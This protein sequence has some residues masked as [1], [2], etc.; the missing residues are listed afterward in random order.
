MRA[1]DPT[2]LY[3]YQ[4]PVLFI[5][6][7]A[8]CHSAKHRNDLQELPEGSRACSSVPLCMAYILPHTIS[9]FP[10]A[11]T[12]LQSHPKCHPLTRWQE[13][14]NYAIHFSL[15]FLLRVTKHVLWS[16]FEYSIHINM[17]NHIQNFLL[18]ILKNFTIILIFLT[19]SDLIFFLLL[20]T[21]FSSDK[22]Y[23][24]QRQFVP[25]QFFYHTLPSIY[26][27]V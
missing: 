2:W 3:L 24:P 21:P 10:S 11:H 5:F 9:V 7:Y 22:E 26:R 6:I 15:L 4:Y 17:Q 18:V 1:G 12:P 25:G 23:T 16:Y 13:Y 8:G 14:R 27:S 19:L 20:E